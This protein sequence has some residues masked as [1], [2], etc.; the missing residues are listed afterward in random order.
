MKRRLSRKK[1]KKKSNIIIFA[2]IRFVRGWTKLSDR[3]WGRRPEGETPFKLRKGFSGLCR[4]KEFP[5]RFARDRF[6]AGK[7]LFL[8]KIS[9][10]FNKLAWFVPDT[11]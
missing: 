1:I 4:K 5:L 9:L 10:I 11:C 3:F 2:T 7:R 8:E 6:K